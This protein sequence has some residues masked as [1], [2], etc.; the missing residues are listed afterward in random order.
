MNQIRQYPE[1]YKKKVAEKLD[2]IFQKKI[3]EVLQAQ[4][5]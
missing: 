3:K 1:S 5:E 2:A 4:S